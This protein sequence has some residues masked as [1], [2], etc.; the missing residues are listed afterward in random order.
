MLSIAKPTLLLDEQ[1]CRENIQRMAEK[2]DRNNVF[3]RPHFKT[4]QSLEVGRWFKEYGVTAITV[5]SI[6]MANYFAQ[7]W[8]DITV[9]FPVNLLE[10]SVI[11]NLASRVKLNLLL[12]SKTA[13][14]FL[15][16]ELTVDVGCFLKIDTGYHR[17]GLDPENIAEIQE[18]ADVFANSKYMNFKGFLTH[19]GHTYTAKD[20]GSIR[21]IHERSTEVLLHL[22]ALY[23]DRFPEL[24]I[25]I[26]DTPGCSI[27][28]D[29]AGIDEI[30]PGNFVFYDLMQT[31]LGSNSIGDI[32]VC[33]ACPVVAVHPKR[34][35]LIIYGGAVHF[36]KEFL[37]VTDGERN[38]GQVAKPGNPGWGEPVPGM[39][40]VKL[41]Q[42]HGTISVPESL[43]DAYLPGD[44]I[45]IL[46]VHS[47]L[48]AN[49]QP[50]F[51]LLSGNEI[52]KF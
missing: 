7:E 22:K 11:N 32:A 48:T 29:F 24:I 45:H 15:A 37:E 6:E 34:N 3:F 33:M 38:Y 43:R 19:S 20:T 30:R 41:S 23:I 8:D 14:A 40:L 4:H 26:G 21:Q 18:I 17:T 28:E 49:L 10:T 44:I 5:S 27:A 13:A 47:C 35:E 2:A 31:Q 39:Q 52:P 25:S 50:S 1:K 42:E 9:A 16:K 46:P 36:S 12:E 51:T